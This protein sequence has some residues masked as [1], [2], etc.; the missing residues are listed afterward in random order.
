MPEHHILAYSPCIENVTYIED[1]HLVSLFD[2]REILLNKASGYFASGD[3]L[4]CSEI[5]TMSDFSAGALYSTVTDMLLWDEALYN[6]KLVS[7]E[8]M[9]EI[10]TPYKEKNGYGWVIDNNLNRKRVRHSGGGTYEGE[11]LKYEFKRDEDNLYFIQ[12]GK[13]GMP[14]YK[15]SENS[16]HHTWL[17]KEYIFEKDEKGEIYFEGVKKKC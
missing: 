15:V 17:D 3:G 16:F 9:K 7:K 4:I 6:E 10:F 1:P 14:I 2:Y 5:D 8:T 11:Y 13:W 12:E